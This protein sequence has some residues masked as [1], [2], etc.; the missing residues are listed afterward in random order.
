MADPGSQNLG[1]QPPQ[2]LVDYEKSTSVVVG[3]S[4]SKQALTIFII[5]YPHFSLQV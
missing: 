3:L 1:M 2:L 5:I 4:D